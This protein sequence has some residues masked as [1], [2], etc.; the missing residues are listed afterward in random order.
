MEKI[1]QQIK[2]VF[3]TQMEVAIKYYT[4]LSV[5]NNLSLSEREVQLIA[6]TAIKGNISTGGKKEEFIKMFNSSRGT[7]G[8]MMAKLGRM[9]M[10]TKIGGKI[11][12][13]PSLILDF[14]N[15]YIYLN[16]CKA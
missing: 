2:K 10:F 8:N 12:V 3:P 5:L 6:F 16:I 7:I 4:I 13:H 1:V 11:C 15:A 14:N 9:G